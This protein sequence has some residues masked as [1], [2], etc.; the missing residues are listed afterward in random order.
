[1]FTSRKHYI[2]MSVLCGNCFAPLFSRVE[3]KNATVI[4]LYVFEFFPCCHLLFSIL[5]E[6]L[7]TEFV[8]NTCVANCYPYFIVFL[9]SGIKVKLLCTLRVFARQFFMLH[10]KNIDKNVVR[11]V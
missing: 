6:S 7:R 2:L 9:K 1:M 11:S 5:S 10:I 3:R 8:L 4:L